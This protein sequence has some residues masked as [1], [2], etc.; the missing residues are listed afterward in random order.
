LIG[1]RV[2]CRELLNSETLFDYGVKKGEIESLEAQ[3]SEPGFWDVQARAQAVVSKLKGLTLVV[4]P[5]EEVMAIGENIEAAIELAEDDPS[6][7]EELISECDKATVI[8]DDLRLKA[9][10]NGPLDNNNAIV[11]IHARD[12]GTDAND[13]A[14]MLLRMYGYWASAHDFEI[15]LIERQENEEAGINFATFAV[16]GPYAFGYLKGE[17]GTHRLVRISP[18]N[19]EGKRQT[20]FAFVDV[21]PEIDDDIDIQIDEKDVKEDTMRA[22]GAGGQHVNKTSSAIRLTHLP[23]GVAVRCEAER[24]Q[25][26][27]RATAWKMLKAKLVAL[28]EQKRDDEEAARYANRPKTGFGSQIRSYFQHPDQRVKDTRTGF[29]MNHFDTVMNG[30]IQGFLDAFLRWRVGEA[31]AEEE[32]NA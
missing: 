4:R 11:T 24:S 10:L 7:D 14:D 6:M 15:E 27:N 5:L 13:W 23:T 9:L 16:R 26:K 17:T 12:G 30:G 18:F 21:T 32:A 19:S 31:V 28:E 22:S 1:R 20:S 8:L 2:S 3:M 25:H 29:S